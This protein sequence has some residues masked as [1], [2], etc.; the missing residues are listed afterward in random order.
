MVTVIFTN[1]P[2]KEFLNKAN[3]FI[4]N[5]RILKYVSCTVLGLA[6]L[7]L[8]LSASGLTFGY[9]VSYYDKVIAIVSSRQEFEKAEKSVL[10]QLDE[11]TAKKAVSS[12]KY[13]LTLTVSQNFFDSE[14][15]AKAIINNNEDIVCATAILLNGTPVLCSEDPEITSIVN[16][17][18]TEYYIEG[19]ENSAEFEE[20]IKVE[21]GYYLKSYLATAEEIRE[22]VNALDV[23]TVSVITKEIEIPFETTNVKTDKKPI[24]YTKITREGE[25]GIAKKTEE[26]VSVNGK[27]TLKTALAKTVVKEQVSK[28]VT[29]GTGV[30]YVNATA[31]A[32]VAAAGF[33]CPLKKGSYIVSAYYGD[34]RNHKGIDLA[35][36]CG[37]PIFAAADGKVIYSGWDGDYGYSVVIQHSNGMKTRYAHANALCVKTGAKVSQGDMIA[38]VGSTGWS[39]G[40]HLH[41]EIIIGGNRVNPG[42]YIG[43]R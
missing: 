10:S 8:T 17:R 26:I 2:V 20:D 14:E 23:K 32:Q 25:N 21:E 29:V 19:A 6:S 36:N 22:Y 1:L 38:T 30:N 15:I 5:S 35:A 11:K 3:K 16:E 24:G 40:N 34:G 4:K 43:L 31:K 9:N 12:P 41:F 33:I 27:T 37:T 28:V 7:L 18:L 39:T 42:P 13:G